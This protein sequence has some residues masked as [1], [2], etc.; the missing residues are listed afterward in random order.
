MASTL[1]LDAAR[2]C[3]RAISLHSQNSPAIARIHLISV[4]LYYS[5]TGNV[6]PHEKDSG[7]FFCA[8]GQGLAGRFFILIIMIY[9]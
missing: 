7:V 3:I 6:N 8:T 4:S 1:P 2:L 9:H 5:F